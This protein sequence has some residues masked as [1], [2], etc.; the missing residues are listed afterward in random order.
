MGMTGRVTSC[1]RAGAEAAQAAPTPSSSSANVLLRI[2]F[3]RNFERLQET[4]VLRRDLNLR[5]GTLFLKHVLVHLDMQRFEEAPVLRCD[6]GALRVAARQADRRV[7]LQYDVESG[8]SYARNGL[9]N[10]R[11]IR[12]GVI[13]GMAELTKQLF[14]MIVQLHD[15]PFPQGPSL[16]ILWRGRNG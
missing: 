16:L 12:H 3:E 11:R 1:A 2:I 15:A 13:D 6:P 14:E 8:R 4:D 9:R 10:P 5:R 7:Q